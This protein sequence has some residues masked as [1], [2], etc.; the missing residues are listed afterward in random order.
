MSEL[1]APIA[2]L[3]SSLA[4]EGPRVGERQLFLRTAGCPLECVYCDT[5]TDPTRPC[6]VEDPPGSGVQ[7]AYENPLGAATVLELLRRLHEAFPGHRRL[8][9]TGGEPLLHT[10]F[11]LE[12]L[13]SVEA[14]LGLPVHLEYSGALPTELERLLPHCAAVSCDVKPPSLAGRDLSTATRRSLELCVTAGVELALKIIFGRDSSW[15]EL[16]AGLE[17][18]QGAAPGVGVILQPVHGPGGLP[19]LSG[20]ELLETLI[21]ASRL[22]PDVRLIPQVHKL[23]AVR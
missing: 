12:L 22:H 19:D 10:D 3:F 14:D 8:A 11:L 4:G 13:P 7:R 15:E 18:A 20:P 21:R 16:V 17:L 23:L 6:L 2:E 5:P 1:R 9:L